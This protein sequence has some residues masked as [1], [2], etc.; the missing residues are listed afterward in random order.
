MACSIRFAMFTVRFDE[1][2][3]IMVMFETLGRWLGD[4]GLRQTFFRSSEK[5]LIRCNVRLFLIQR[6]HIPS[7]T[8][9]LTGRF[10]LRH[11]GGVICV[12]LKTKDFV[13]HLP[14]CSDWG[15]G[16]YANAGKELCVVKDKKACLTVASTNSSGFLSEL[17]TNPGR[18]TSIWIIHH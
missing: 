9:F 11:K 7:K 16:E 18:V 4:G 15:S 10:Q 6:A 5:T 14:C 12:P 13:G 8:K 2:I 17:G 3:R 1:N